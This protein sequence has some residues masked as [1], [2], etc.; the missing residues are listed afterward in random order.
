MTSNERENT[1]TPAGRP[2]LLPPQNHLLT[3][4]VR[5]PIM[6]ILYINKKVRFGELQRLLH[7]TAGNLEHHL[8]KL[9]ETNY[10]I[11]KKELFPKRTYTIIMITKVGENA[12][13][14]YSQKL[15]DVLD[16]VE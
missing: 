15:R 6:L 5:F 7:L 4:P 9:E 12:F 16:K 3:S 1:K 14:D 10:I 2:D 8:K 11:R 13:K